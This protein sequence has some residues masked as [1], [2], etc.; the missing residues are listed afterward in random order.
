MKKY[1]FPIHLSRVVPDIIFPTKKKK[2]QLINKVFEYESGG[3]K[4]ELL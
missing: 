3:S 4:F 1:C 2:K